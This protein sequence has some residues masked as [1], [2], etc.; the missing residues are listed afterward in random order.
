LKK[1]ATLLILVAWACAVPRDC[2]G[3]DQ[4]SVVG[5]QAIPRPAETPAKVIVSGRTSTAQSI[6]I[7]DLG[8]RIP[9]T[10]AGDRFKNTKVS[11]GTSANITLSRLTSPRK[12]RSIT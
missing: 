5:T 2:L 8:D 3:F 11:P 4:P 9:P 1:I 7:R 10:F 6:L 12:E